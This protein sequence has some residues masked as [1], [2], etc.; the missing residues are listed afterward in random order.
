MTRNIS[1]NDGRVH[2]YLTSSVL[3]PEVD[4][5]LSFRAYCE[6]ESLSAAIAHT[7]RLP[8][9]SAGRDAVLFCFLEGGGGEGGEEKNKNKIRTRWQQQRI[10]VL[11]VR[12][13]ENEY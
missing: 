1:S 2:R 10:C 4:F 12:C 9:T 5:P 6:R 3:Q 11:G 13:T 8:A 7:E